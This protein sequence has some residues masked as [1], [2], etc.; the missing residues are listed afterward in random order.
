MTNGEEIGT[1]LLM[2]KM[3]GMPKAPRVLDRA[4]LS[5][6]FDICG[7]K[8]PAI[9][10]KVALPS[11]CAAGVL[12]KVRHGIYINKMITPVPTADEVA[13]R[14]RSGSVISLHRVLG[15]SGVLNNPTEWITCVVPRSKSRSVGMIKTLQST[16]TF[17]V[18]RDEFFADNSSD[19]KSDALEAFTNAPT[20]TPEK[21]LM[22]WLYLSYSS[23]H[24][25]LTP[26]AAHDLD[27]SL[28]DDERLARLA[29]RMDLKERL[30]TLLESS[31]AANKAQD[32]H[33][34]SPSQASRRLHSF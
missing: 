14:L 20:A 24:S 2:I 34:A 10:L 3:L 16:F 1:R 32:E 30:A 11:L 8:M 21:A 25:N 15:R 29:E 9:T 7:L 26:P 12:S 19:W 4:A 17:N 31:T 27:F 5:A 13:Q 28:L 33:V 23:P 18:M 6:W 22:D